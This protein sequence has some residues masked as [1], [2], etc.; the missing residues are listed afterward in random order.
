MT[1]R[2]PI[3][4]DPIRTD[5]QL[6]HLH[7]RNSATSRDTQPGRLTPHQ[8]ETL[9]NMGMGMDSSTSTLIVSAQ[10]PLRQLAALQA[11]LENIHRNHVDY[12]DL[13]SQR[14][15]QRV[16]A[17]LP[18]Q[19]AGRLY[20]LTGQL[21][22]QAVPTPDTFIGQAMGSIRSILGNIRFFLTPHRNEIEKAPEQLAFATTFAPFSETAL[23]AGLSISDTSQLLEY[24]AR[25]LGLRITREEALALTVQGASYLNYMRV[26]SHTE[27]YTTYYRVHNRMSQMADQIQDQ[28]SSIVQRARLWGRSTRGVDESLS[29][30]NDRLTQI[31]LEVE[32]LHRQLASQATAEQINHISQSESDYLPSYADLYP[33]SIEIEDDI[34][35]ISEEISPEIS[36]S[37]TQ[38]S[39]KHSLIQPLSSTKQPNKSVELIFPKFPHPGNAIKA[40]SPLSLLKRKDAH[41]EMIDQIIDWYSEVTPPNEKQQELPV[42]TPDTYIVPQRMANK[43]PKRRLHP[44]LYVIAL[45]CDTLPERERKE[46]ISIYHQELIQKEIS[47]LSGIVT[48]LTTSTQTLLKKINQITGTIT[49]LIESI[50]TSIDLVMPEKQPLKEQV[51]TVENSQKTIMNGLKDIE[52]KQAEIDAVSTITD[53]ELLS[54]LL[55][56]NVTP[57]LVLNGLTTQN[58]VETMTNKLR[59][60][61]TLKAAIKEQFD[62]LENTRHLSDLNKLTAASPNHHQSDQMDQLINIITQLKI[63]FEQN[64]TSIL[65]TII[66]F[67]SIHNALMKHIDIQLSKIF[68]GKLQKEMQD[69]L[70]GLRVLRP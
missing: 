1:H 10:T 22:S 34:T 43:K 62:E 44:S 6:A 51:T 21:L 37:S 55:E 24:Q 27:I 38:D 68:D 57:D 70:F 16:A 8:V 18:I 42:S 14:E 65:D 53:Q 23:N 2:H 25:N 15:I 47:Q 3:P 19:L 40:T 31:G 9:A 39:R 63:E 5:P 60:I 52:K 50:S 32:Y 13:H 54:D 46:M 45:W 41:Q 69:L 26:Q 35:Y 28:L 48:Q 66:K 49:T 64:I 11:H 30:I 20:E 12:E 58:Q 67:P 29:G 56:A 4:T 7:I 61:I 36:E 17:H 59:E 33:D